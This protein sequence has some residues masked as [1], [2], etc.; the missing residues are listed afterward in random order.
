MAFS[1][2]SLS[3]EANEEMKFVGFMGFSM[4][5]AQRSR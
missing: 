4:N 2:H 1:F 5:E 3:A